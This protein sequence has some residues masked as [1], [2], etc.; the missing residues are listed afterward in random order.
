LKDGKVE[1]TWDGRADVESGLKQFHVYRDGQKVASVGGLVSKVN[2]KGAYQVWNYGDEP[3][4]APAPPPQ[5]LDSAGMAASRYEVTAE[6]HA[7][8]E[9]PKSKAAVPGS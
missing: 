3:E 7:G 2:P 8:L 6:N 1:L 9:S 4:P 5:F